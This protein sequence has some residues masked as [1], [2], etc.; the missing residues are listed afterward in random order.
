MFSGF[1][2]ISRY[3]WFRV[4][5]ACISLFALG[6]MDNA[7]GPFFPILLEKTTVSSSEGALFFALTSFVAIISSALASFFIARFGLKALLVCGGLFM[8]ASPYGLVFMPSLT[9]ALT[10][11][12]LFGASLGMV[13]VGQNVLV[14]QIE[15]EEFK[16]RFFSLL[17]CFYA[18]AAMTAPLSVLAL[19]NFVVWNHILVAVSFL[20][21]PFIIFV[22]FLRPENSKL[23]S[24]QE[25]KSDSAPLK[26][27]DK[28][29]FLWILFMSFYVSSELILS[30]RMVVLVKSFSKPFDVASHHLFYFF[31]FMLFS[32]LLFFLFQFKSSTYKVL[33]LCMIGG[34]VGA[35]LGYSIDP[36]F[37][38]V[39]G[40]FMGP[41]FPT[42]MEEVSKR[43][44][45]NFD[46]MVSR[47]I[48]LSSFFVVLTHMSVGR[49]TDLY[50]VQ[51]SLMVVPVL[52][53]L[54]FSVLMY[55]RFKSI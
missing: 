55:K 49:L 33:T 43:W 34:F 5:V 2:D 51:Q 38:S 21:V 48:S 46:V 47:V 13:A 37:F 17:H 36:F 52:L 32:R 45:K 24:T 54:A 29:A 19:K 50:G 39:V 20:T 25:L 14:G 42:V 12:F 4:F 27:G 1:K 35:I 10:T 9:G 7:R 11:A 31:L 15:N 18:L 16:R 44:P 8:T 26:W 53:A 22:L 6:W 3:T 30:T 40:G 41:V 28:A 23:N